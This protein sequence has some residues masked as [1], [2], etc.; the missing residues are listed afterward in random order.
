MSR[1]ATGSLSEQL[2]GLFGAGTCAGFSDGELLDRF[3]SSRDEAGERAFESLVTRHGPMVLGICRHFLDDPNDAHDAFQAVFLVLARRAGA[4][5]KSDSVGSWLYGVTVRV[6]ARARATAIRRKVRDRRV[7][8]AASAVSLAGGSPEA[9]PDRSLEHDDGAKLVHEEVVRLPERYRTPIV[10]CYFEGLTHDEA[11]ARLSWP[12]GTVRSR[13]ARARDRLR[14]RLTRRGLAAPATIGPLAA[15]LIAGQSPATASAAIRA[16]ATV[17]LPT[18]VP[19]SLARAAVRLV[20]GQPSAAGL[21]SSDSTA[22]AEGVLK[23]MMLK[24]LAVAGCVVL[25]LGVGTGTGIVM[26][27]EAGAQNPSGPAATQAGASAGPQRPQAAAKTNVDPL[28]QRFLS[29]A[30]QRVEAQRA[31]YEEGRI[32]IDRFIDACTRLKKAELLAATDESE[33]TAARE[34]YLNVL[35]EIEQREDAELKVGRGTVADLSEIRQRRQQAEMDLKNQRDEPDEYRAKALKLLEAARARYEAQATY[36]KEG[37]ITI[38]RL[39]DA[40]HQ[41]ADAEQRTARTDFE[42]VA[43]RK[44]HVDRLKEIEAR[45]EAQL[46]AGRSTQGDMAEATTRRIEAELELHEALT[47][48]GPADLAPVLR[49]LDELE[50]KVEQLQKERNGGGRR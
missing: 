45:E 32:T 22:M 5:R 46:K 11:A 29:A 42:R 15:W 4:I 43:S 3:R 40:S 27:R 21:W 17:S 7:L 9:C 14:T 34:W 47:N 26:T 48:K 30:R 16:A 2:A 6:A 24:K 18:H 1:V 33:R 37:R 10:L 20:A 36:F 28:A 19:A 50:K 41:F 8:E 35:L 12:V 39:A 49:R 44:R 23:T 31:Y 13:L 38:D 25:S